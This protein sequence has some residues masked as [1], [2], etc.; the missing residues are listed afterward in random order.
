[1]KRNSVTLSE[2]GSAVSVFFSPAV[3]FFGSPLRGVGDRESQPV[4]RTCIQSPST[5]YLR[6][7]WQL[8]GVLLLIVT[9]TVDRKTSLIP[10]Q[11]GLFPVLTAFSLCFLFFFLRSPHHPVTTRFWFPIC[12][13]HSGSELSRLLEPLSHS[14]A[15]FL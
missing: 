10:N 15:L 8:T 3:L 5:L 9:C 4:R 12:G 7:S 1:M 13:E 2:T 6:R 11:S 14:S